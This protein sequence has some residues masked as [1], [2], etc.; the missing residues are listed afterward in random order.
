MNIFDV[1][2]NKKK[3]DTS[4]C[5]KANKHDAYT[6]LSS[7]GRLPINIWGDVMLNGSS[8][9]V[10]RVLVGKEAHE[11]LLSFFYLHE[12]LTLGD[13][14]KIIENQSCNSDQNITVTQK[15][16]KDRLFFIIKIV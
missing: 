15:Y 14:I 5:S 2:F 10:R 16:Q 1:L 13:A 4:T 3:N 7:A 9:Q 6:R 12:I 11:C 8:P